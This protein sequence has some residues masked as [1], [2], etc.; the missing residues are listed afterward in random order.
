MLCVL[1][2]LEHAGSPHGEFFQTWGCY[3][4]GVHSSRFGCMTRSDFSLDWAA[5]CPPLTRYTACNG[6]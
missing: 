6:H 3:G 5:F 4:K 1:T 2:G